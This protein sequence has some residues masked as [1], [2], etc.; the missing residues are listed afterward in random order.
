MSQDTINQ[1]RTWLAEQGLDAFLVTQPQNRSYLSGWL[2][3]DDEGAGMLLVGQQHQVLLTNPL[4]KEVAEHEAT[5]WEVVVPPSREYAPAIARLATEY[6]WSNI[7]F[8]AMALLYGVY[9]NIRSAGQEN[10]TLHPFNESI[11]NTLRLVKQ[12]HELELI[13]RAIA[14]TDETFTHLCQWIQP[15]VTEKQVQLEVSNYMVSLGADGP[16]FETIVASG[17]NGSMPHAHAGQRRIQRGELI[18]I[19]MGA[20]Y[21]GYCADMTRTICLGEPAEARMVEIYDAVLNAM[22]TCEAGLHAGITGQAADALARSALEMEGL[23]DYYV[24]S[25]GH[26]LG[27]QVHEGP[28]LSQRAPEDMI[29]PAGSVVTVEPGVYIPDW[30]G[31]RVEDCGLVTENGFEV[32][33]QSP[34]RLVIAR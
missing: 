23:A 34:T 22:K 2:N 4:Y 10:F 5:G 26:G 7:G 21:K 30:G 18:T 32:F 1:L 27:L 24:H 3:D 28:S 15:G 31:V 13:R 12:P 9:E 19:D 14:I 25:T 33:T 6:G 20:R 16:A 29:L 8:E 11:V 17:P